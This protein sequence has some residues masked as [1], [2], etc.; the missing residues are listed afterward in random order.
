[1][2]ISMI[3][4]LGRNRVIGKEGQ[5]PWHLSADLKH[6]KKTTMGKPIIM[7]RRSC[8]S[9]KTDIGSALPLPGRR[10]I[11]I[12]SQTGY[13]VPAGCDL[14]NNLQS[15][16]ELVANEPEIMIAGGTRVYKEAMP[17]A[18]R[19]YLTFIDENFNGDTF[20][21]VWNENEWEIVKEE[22]FEPDKENKYFYRFVT[23]ER[24]N[25]L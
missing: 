14:V 19:M 12:S 25:Q 5:L 4:A 22:T 13:P 23:F 16:L 6:F 8:E 7:G 2:F 10:N 24:V 15:A 9:F 18:S 17:L 11:I 1:M 20:F 3:A 21:P